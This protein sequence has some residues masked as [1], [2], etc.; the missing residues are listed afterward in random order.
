MRR[1]I[2]C[3]ARKRRTFAGVSPAGSTLIA[4]TGTSCPSWSS[5]PRICWAVSG[6]VSLHVEYMNVTIT[7][8]PRYWS[9]VATRPFWSRRRKSIARACGGGSAPCS[10]VG[11]ASPDASSLLP[12]AAISATPASAHSPRVRR[13]RPSGLD[14]PAPDRVAHELDA[15][16]H[17]ELAQHVRAVR[18]D[19]LLG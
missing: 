14:E 1:A 2:C 11:P 15:V 10:P 16:A 5:A 18:L 7:N 13:R 12:L 3:S 6:H 4:S 9:I 19:R 8:R 17:A